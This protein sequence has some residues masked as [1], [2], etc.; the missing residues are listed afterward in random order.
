MTATP[1]AL[2]RWKDFWRFYSDQPHQQKA[3]ELLYAAILKSNS[4]LL[5][6]SADWRQTFSQSAPKLQTNPLAVPY[7]SQLD[8]A[9]GTGY[10]ECFSSSAAMCAMYHGVISSDDA[11]NQTRSRYGDST[12]PNAQVK[13]LQ[14][15]GLMVE[16]RTDGTSKT[17]EGLIDAGCPVPV[18]WLHHGSSQSPTGGGHWTLLI[19][20]TPTH[21]IM[22][23]PNGEAN[24]AAGGYVNHTGG[25]S[26]LYS[27]K[28]WDPRWQ[29]QGTGG[30][31]LK[32]Q[33]K[34]NS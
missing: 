11:Y 26:V 25:K 14:S 7:Q 4:A 1:M 9:S 29:V 24:L 30:W 3:I 17:L 15:L 18:G 13:A 10:R 23:D 34:P 32:V 21:W 19:G 12:D 16:Y 28:N 31:Y 6:E 5:L 27:R 33:R 2:E 20:Y 22:H 8:N